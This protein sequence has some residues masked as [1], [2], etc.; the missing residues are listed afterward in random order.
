[1]NNDKITDF[2]ICRDM[3]IGQGAFSR[4][5]LGY[6]KNDVTFQV[7]IKEI[8]ISRIT[9]NLRTRFFEEISIINIL[10][11]NPHP[12]II[13]C[14][15]IKQD[16]EKIYIVME[17]CKHGELS[18]LLKKKLSENKIKFYFKQIIE[19]LLHLNKLN[20]MHRD[21]K[22]ANILLTDD[23]NTVKVTDFGL[24][25][26]ITKHDLFNTI[27][28][29]PFYMAPELLNQQTH[30]QQTDIWSL[31]IILYEFVYGIHPFKSCYNIIDLKEK[32]NE[33]EIN[34][35]SITSANI[36]INQECINLMRLLLSRNLTNRIKL[37]DI[38]N[39]KWFENE[40]SHN[41]FVI[42]EDYF[43]DNTILQNNS[44]QSNNLIQQNNLIQNNSI[45]NNLIKNDLAQNNSIQN[46]NYIPYQPVIG[47]APNSWASKLITSIVNLGNSTFGYISKI[48][49][50]NPNKD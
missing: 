12:N 29:S 22:P 34:F 18:K 21:I 25:K 46:D 23:G 48:G 9:D 14:Y 5:Y 27:C 49:N 4:V 10:R 36:I 31:G 7:A 16:R 42:L 45:Q 47:S 38:L 41:G 11:Q 44:I 32:V 37:H 24:S 15:S 28:G 17:Y 26:N 19:A 2:V 13:K 40:K 1:M 39:H 3:C 20:I 30:D 43:G 33:T 50:F 35:A 8:N 6:S